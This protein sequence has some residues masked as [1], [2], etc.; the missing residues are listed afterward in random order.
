MFNAN[1]FDTKVIY[2]EAELERPP[3]VAPKPRCGLCFVEALSDKA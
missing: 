3:F 2:D 1:V